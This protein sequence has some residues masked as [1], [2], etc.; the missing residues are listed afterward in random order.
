MLDTL[1]EDLESTA[2]IEDAVL[3]II[4]RRF[5]TPLVSWSTEPTT[6]AEEYNRTHIKARESR[7]ESGSKKM[8]PPNRCAIYSGHGFGF[9]CVG[10]MHLFG[11]DR[12]ERV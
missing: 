4:P 11:V 9:Q 8:P 10:N 7:S 3:G 6:I 12:C 2:G 1:A 5:F